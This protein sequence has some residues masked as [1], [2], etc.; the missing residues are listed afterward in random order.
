MRLT[1]LLFSF[2][3]R[4][5][6]LYWWVTTIAVGAAAGAITGILDVAAT[7]SGH[8]V[9]DT[10]T[11]QTEPTGL[12]AVAV[13]A[14]GLANLWINFALSV[15]RLHDRGRSGWWLVW[16][17]LILVLAV[18]LVVVAIAVPKEQAPIWW[19]LAAPVGF[20][21]LAI[22]L[23]LF[24]EIGC[25]R[26]TQGPNR[27][28]EDPL[29][30]TPAGVTMTGTI[31][32]PEPALPVERQS[33]RHILFG[34]RGRITRRPWWWGT[35]IAILAVAGIAI[36]AAIGHVGWENIEKIKTFDL[37]SRSVWALLV[38]SAI[39][40]WPG[41]ALGFKRLHDRNYS[42]WWAVIPT[43]LACEANAVRATTDLGG[44]FDAPSLIMTLLGSVS[45]LFSLWLRVPCG[46][47]KGRPGPNRF[48]PDPLGR[49][50][51]AAI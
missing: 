46:V 28:G 10:T 19:V 39:L 51:D 48:G 22:S 25:L 42:C 21:A 3:G 34:F 12:Y 23:W 15:K 30:A 11:Q 31:M 17:T 37:H 20:V 47:L 32:R 35:T 41:L 26:G 7:A 44:T 6:R 49:P 29:V 4:I 2:K 1:E 33:L 40:T 43:V 14:V 13:F 24:V 8:S 9:V 36:A 18:I 16:Q 38:V 50:A 27:F 45:S 5:Q